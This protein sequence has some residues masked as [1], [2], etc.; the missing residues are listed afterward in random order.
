MYSALSLFYINSLDYE[1]IKMSHILNPLTS[2]NQLFRGAQKNNALPHELQESIRFYTARLTQAAGLLLRL[3]QSITAQANVLLFRYWVEEGLM[4]NEFSQEVSAATLYLT[5]KISAS[6]VSLRS[7]T[8]VYTYLLSPGS[9]LSPNGKTNSSE[10]PPDPESYYLSESA[11]VAKRTKIIHLEGQILYVLGFH[12]H[13]ALPHPLAIT[14]IQILEFFENDDSKIGHRLAQR[15]IAHLNAALINPQMLYLTHQP[16]QLATAAIFIAAREVGAVLP[17]CAWW[18][19][20][21]CDREDLGFLAVALQ[22]LKSLVA[23]EVCRWGE[24][25]GMIS[26]SDVQTEMAKLG[27]SLPLD[28]RGDQGKVDEETEMARLLDE[29]VISNSNN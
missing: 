14:Y 12:T 20:F 8:N 2:V 19:V 10:L 1:K 5:A 16:C 21:D 3:P 11:Y 25:Q 18:E 24:D 9:M 4:K 27:L 29:K 23:R 6:P 28:D 15:V 22:S 26:R 17:A 7:I 13:V